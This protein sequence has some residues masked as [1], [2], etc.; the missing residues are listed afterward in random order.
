VGSNIKVTHNRGPNLIAAN[1]ERLESADGS[2][3]ALARNYKRRLPDRRY[4][5][6]RVWTLKRRGANGRALELHKTLD[7]AEAVAWIERGELPGYL[8][9]R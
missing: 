1:P 2:R 5:G 7:R 9:R 4:E 3:W 6:V 8:A